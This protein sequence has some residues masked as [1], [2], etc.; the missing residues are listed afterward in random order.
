MT[1]SSLTLDRDHDQDLDH[2]FAS[3]SDYEE[4]DNI[5]D[6]ERRALHDLFESTNGRNWIWKQ[7]SASGHWNFTD[8]QVNPCVSN[9]GSSWEGITCDV[10][11]TTQQLQ[12]STL[13]HHRLYHISK[14]KLP[15]YNLDGSIPESIEYLSNLLHLDLSSNVLVGSI[16]LTIA[17]TT[18]MQQLKLFNNQMR[19]SLPSGIYNLSQLVNISIANNSFTGSLSNSISRLYNL[20]YLS[21]S[22]NKF[23]G[24]IPLSI[25]N[26]SSL[27][28]LDI[29]VN[30]FVGRIPDSI[31]NLT[32]VTTIKLNKNKLSHSI[33]EA[34]GNLTQ[35]KYLDL[36]DNLISKTIPASI[37]RC[38]ALQRLDVG[39]N[40]LT[41]TLPSYLGSLTKLTYISLRYNYYTGSIP[42]SYANLVSLT[43]FRMN[44]NAIT[45]SL[46]SFIG[47]MV[48]MGYFSFRYNNFS[49]SIPSS[50]SRLAAMQ[51]F[52]VNN[53]L[54]TGSIPS[55]LGSLSNLNYLEVGNNFF[56][57]S[58]PSSF[59]RLSLMGLL[60]LNYNMLT[61]TVPTFLG[62]LSYLYVLD[63]SGNAF[64]GTIP[65]TLQHL[66]K[67]ANF[68]FARNLLT[69]TI[70]DIFASL[71][72]MTGVFLDENLLSGTIPASLSTLPDLV[73]CFLE[74][75]LLTG[76]VTTIFNPVIQKSLADIQISNNQLTGT[77]S[78]GNGEVGGGGG[79]FESLSSFSAVTNCF[80]SADVSMICRNTQLQTLSWDGLS[81][82]SSCRHKILPGVSS[83]YKSSY[84]IGGTLPACLFDMQ[85][86]SVLHLS[87]NGFIGSLP[88]IV[89]MSDALTDLSL[90]YNFLTGSI[91]SVLQS[92][93]WSKLDLSYNRLSGTL[94]SFNP[95]SDDGYTLMLKNNRLSGDIPQAA[96]GFVTISILEG[97][98]FACKKDRSDLPTRDDA[99][100]SYECGSDGFNSS[101]YLWLTLVG[102]VLVVAS[103]LYY[104]RSQAIARYVD[105]ASI[106]R[107]VLRWNNIQHHIDIHNNQQHPTSK[108]R[109]I[110]L[111]SGYQQYDV[112]QSL[113]FR[114]AI[115]TSAFITVVL[116]PTYCILR[117]YFSTHTY[118]YAW[119]V[120]ATS[121]AGKVSFGVLM[122][123][124]CS[125]MV[126]QLVAYK[127]CLS[128][129]DIVFR[130][131]QHTQVFDSRFV[132]RWLIYTGYVVFN[133]MIV[134]GVNAAYVL[135]ILKSSNSAKVFFQ[136]A[137]SIFKL[138]WNDGVSPTTVRWI[139]HYISVHGYDHKYSFKRM[140]FLQLFTALNVNIIIPYLAVMII[141][142]NCFY[143]AL[144]S[145][146]TINSSFF[147]QSC[148]EFTNEQC[149]TE[150]QV[151]ANTSYAPPFVYNY[152]C[153]AGIITSYASVYVYVS[154]FST[155]FIPMGKLLLLKAHKSS[156]AN[157]R[158]FHA[159]YFFLPHILRP[160]SREPEETVVTTA[161]SNGRMETLQH[162]HRKAASGLMDGGSTV[163]IISPPSPPPMKDNMSTIKAV[164]A[165]AADDDNGN[166]SSSTVKRDLLH[167]YYNANLIVNTNFLTVAL[168]LTFGVVFPPLAL[169]LAIS[170][171]VRLKFIRLSVGRLI[172]NSIEAHQLS[173]LRIVDE[174]CDKVVSENLFMNCI[175]MVLGVCSCF[176]SMFL[177]DTLGDTVGFY[178]S[179]WVFI[180]MFVL[181]ACLYGAYRAILLYQARMMMIHANQQSSD[182]A[183]IEMSSFQSNNPMIEV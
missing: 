8:L 56:V 39:N 147:Y 43:S 131:K 104:Y 113:L 65:S 75:N 163:D 13:L 116:L 55:F 152:Q 100:G 172:I 133:L 137:L 58:I 31:G 141:S 70:P 120:S 36:G 93:S 132:K 35:L 145:R 95:P 151:E 26:L 7:K 125:L 178:Q 110:I 85:Q 3:L 69:G 138:A 45:G 76:P 135:A 15:S 68:G 72:L 61:S 78:F 52:K 20:Q 174:E 57:G 99:R 79:G 159:T 179:Y 77:L 86:L 109:N 103:C 158:L 50:Y 154:I 84:L 168:I 160:F 127:Y 171:V 54:L 111:M 47:D 148:Q 91:P 60:S 49:G 48:S 67:L 175:F 82:A 121:L 87:G 12:S 107:H 1:S 139:L 80:C 149:T 142:T 128:G 97:N 40:S 156:K 44:N 161:I 118:E 10:V 9:A 102:V 89:S 22:S 124:W 16:P 136:I 6:S 92:R 106:K 83:A 27:A 14:I 24:T 140:L 117:A 88:R 165:T 74:N 144:N 123:L 18:R 90:S 4:P 108:E 30:S 32:Q 94:R 155:F 59:S 11:N 41:G 146:S 73:G 182:K 180:V 164:A 37:V 130:V 33:P 53:N 126:A 143:Y 98:L 162:H 71:P 5:P 96:T 150:V 112:I 134:A 23:D 63:L 2:N 157:S 181:P 19:G 122:S 29:G 38:S 167:P 166:S 170:S 114:G 62:Y 101:Y 183:N 46:P 25:A 64:E 21:I 153:S 173:Y 66:S 81:S 115:Y 176:Y 51:V 119:T 177:F 105:L 28:Y 129:F 42:S 169:C 17:N 34:I